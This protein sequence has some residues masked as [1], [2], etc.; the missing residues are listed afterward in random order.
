VDKPVV[1][2]G[3]FRA[4]GIRQIR[5][6]DFSN[7]DLASGVSVAVISQSVARM[8]SPS[9][10]VIGKRVT[11]QT[12]PTPKDW[13]NVIG[14]V[15][16]VKQFGPAQAAHPAVY[17]LYLQVERPFLLN[18]M[19]FA[20][21]TTGDPQRAIPG[22]LRA[23]DKNQPA[24]SMALMT[25][26]LGAATAEPAFQTRLLGVI[27]ALMLMLALV[28]TYGVLTS[29]VAQRTHEI[30]VRMALG[31]RRQSV[32]WMVIRQTLTLGLAGIVLG[33][34]GALLAT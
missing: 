31:A 2:A 16:D 28:G 15:E 27:A 5:G 22:M 3:Y 4:M 9:E 33:T 7:D 32:L 17:Q 21:R 25:D 23:V 30:G 8:I 29:S 34:A 24:E 6:R 14:V 20:V 11:L 1:S 10:D 13:L 18:H 26:V 19:T 12:R